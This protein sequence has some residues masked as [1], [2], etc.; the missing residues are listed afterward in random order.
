MPDPER[1]TSARRFVLET[2]AVLSG[3]LIAFGLDAGWGTLRDRS[4]LR[5]S[6][7]LLREEF[8]TA[9][10][11]MD[12]VLAVNGRAIEATSILL[13]LTPSGALALSADEVQYLWV[14]LQRALR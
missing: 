14:P 7:S 13:E 5:E 1:R 9:R 8:A 10:V 4:E 11:Q 6:L 3:I 12:T 2:A